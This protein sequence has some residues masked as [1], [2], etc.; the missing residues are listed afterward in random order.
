MCFRTSDVAL[1]RIYCE[2]KDESK[3]EKNS[4]HHTKKRKK[5]KI[6][7]AAPAAF[8]APVTFFC[9]LFKTPSIVHIPPIPPAFLTDIFA[10]H[11][12]A[13]QDVASLPANQQEKTIIIAAMTCKCL[14][15]IRCLSHYTAQVLIFANNTW[16]LWAIS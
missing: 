5:R 2:R 4:L 14:K 11:L 3:G 10:V 1:K 9:M 15:P 13:Q 16:I 12:A 6:T 7:L 8:S